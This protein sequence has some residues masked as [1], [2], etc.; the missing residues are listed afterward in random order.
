MMGLNFDNN[1]I[2]IGW[3]DLFNYNSLAEIEASEELPMPQGKH[4]I[5]SYNDENA[6]DI[7]E[8]VNSITN[9]QDS[10]RKIQLTAQLLKQLNQITKDQK[11]IKIRYEY[12]TEEQRNF[13]DNVLNK[14]E[15]T[16]F[17]SKGDQIL[18]NYVSTTIQK[19]IQKLGNLSDAYS[20]VEISALR[21]MLPYCPKQSLATSLTLFNPAMVPVMQNTNMTGKQGTG[22]AANGQKGLF[23]WRF[24]TLDTLR[25]NPEKQNLVKFNTTIKRVLG[26]FDYNQ[27]GTPLTDV[28]LESLPDLGKITDGM[29]VLH[30]KIKSDNIGSQYISA[31]TDNAKEL[32][33]AN[34]NAGTKLMKCH[35]YLMSLGFD[36]EDIVS[37]MTSPAVSFIDSIASDNIFNG[38]QISVNDAIE[39]AESYI[40]GLINYNN[41]NDLDSKQK[42]QKSLDQITIKGIRGHI[43]KAFK[44]KLSKTVDLEGFLEDLKSLKN[45][46]VGANEFSTFA[47]ILG[48]N[49]GIPQTKEDLIAFKNKLKFAMNAATKA[50]GLKNSKGN[51]QYGKVVQTWAM[52]QFPSL[53]IDGVLDL[54][55]AKEFFNLKDQ[56][57]NS[58]ENAIIQQFENEFQDV[59]TLDSDKWLEDQNYRNKVSNFYNKVKHTINLFY[60][61]DTIPHYKKMFEIANV[62]N[63]VD[64]RIPLKSQISNYFNEELRQK[65]PYAPKGFEDRLLPVIDEVLLGHYIKSTGLELKLKDNWKILDSDYSITENTGNLSLSTDHDIASFKYVFETYII[66]ELKRGTLLNDKEQNDAIRDNQFIKNLVITNDKGVPLYKEDIDLMLV[67]SNN[68]TKRKYQDLL[69]GIKAL[70]NYKYEG[71]PLSDLFMLYNI[72]VNKNRYG[73]ERMTEIFEDFVL[74]SNDMNSSYLMNYLKTLGEWD[75][76]K[77]LF[78]KI[79][80]SVTLSDL[81]MKV[82][83]LVGRIDNT[84]QEPFVKMLVPGKGYQYI[85]KVGRN[86]NTANPIE[87]LL[88]IPG[89][90]PNKT[91]ER[92]INFLENGFGLVY[93]QSVDEIVSNLMSDNFE[94]ILDRLIQNNTLSYITNCNE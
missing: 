14:H 40:V 37:F 6:L 80:S 27:N 51:L 23:M 8:Q 10:V 58:V 71:I 2:Y 85:E 25:N 26:R 78:N 57:K 65:Y 33:L 31:A 72:I 76:N 83:P 92:Q 94:F 79:I 30:P 49:Q 82:A 35:L 89:E 1:G 42:V 18:K 69:Q 70:R 20:P 88:E 44:N 21:K 5:Y 53:F 62:L 39:F 22:I 66:P 54:K 48:I 61:L 9:E 68:E 59:I 36:V 52:E 50:S 11:E 7:T 75:Y 32:I 13:A 77:S 74:D 60:F 91:L 73:S 55:A 45:I 41:A 28:T 63:Q 3:S 4:Y 90:L 93:S 46:I 86:Y 24:G 56:S 84:R 67:N 16:K 15:E 64:K 47:A 81:L 38:T 17:G 29:S 19:L 87:L 34:I 43:L 12:S